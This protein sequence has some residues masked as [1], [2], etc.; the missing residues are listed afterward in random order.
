MLWAAAAEDK[1]C[2]EATAVRTEE[3]FDLTLAMYGSY[4][5]EMHNFLPLRVMT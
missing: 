2:P 1:G 4:S 5:L 3:M